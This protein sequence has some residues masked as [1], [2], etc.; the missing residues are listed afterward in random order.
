MIGSME[1]TTR[2]PIPEVLRWVEQQ[3][4]QA[5]GIEALAELALQI[6][7]KLARPK[8]RK[9]P[10]NVE[11]GQRLKIMRKQLSQRELAEQ[12][13]IDPSEVSRA[14]RGVRKAHWTLIAWLKLQE[15]Q[16]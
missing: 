4:A 13:M 14:E 11:F 6:K 9:K 5:G 3:E 1:A 16:S 10:E 8:Q 2:P 15:S 7:P 12:L